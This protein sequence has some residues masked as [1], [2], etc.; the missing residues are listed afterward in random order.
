MRSI[1]QQPATTIIVSCQRESPIEQTVQNQRK[2]SIAGDWKVD[3]QFKDEAASGTTDANNCKGL[4]ACL[5]ILQ[6]GEA[7]AVDTS[8]RLGRS[9]VVVP[10]QISLM[11]KR[12]IRFVILRQVI[13]TDTS[14]RKLVLIKFTAFADFEH[15]IPTERQIESISRVPT[16]G[17]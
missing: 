12:G 2:A 1:S 9:I 11:S 13:D 4:A 15:R 6:K 5:V 16:K 3:I 10:T 7:L 8:N 17:M 14:A